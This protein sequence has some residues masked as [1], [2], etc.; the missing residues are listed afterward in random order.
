MLK[1]HLH[2]F[3]MEYKHYEALRSI[4]EPTEID[5]VK[6]KAKDKFEKLKE[7]RIILQKVMPKINKAYAK[8]LMER[9]EADPKKVLNYMLI[10]VGRY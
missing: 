6:S 10:S 1:A 7:N 3:L 9:S 2:G 4:A 8:E 5:V